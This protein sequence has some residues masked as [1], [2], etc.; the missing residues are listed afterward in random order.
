[1]GIKST[2]VFSRLSQRNSEEVE[3]KKTSYWL[4]KIF[5][6]EKSREKTPV[7]PP[8]QS[9]KQV[10][11]KKELPENNKEKAVKNRQAVEDMIN[12]SNRVLLRIY[13]VFPLDFFP[14]RI[15]VED[16]RLVIIH[17][18]LFSSQVHSVDLKDVSN[19]FIDT[20]IIFA[21]VRVISNTFAQNQIIVNKLWK[22]EAILARNV[23]EGLR[24]FI[25]NG[26]D[27]T[28]FKTEE[29]V[30]KLKELNETEIVI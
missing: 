11:P 3:T 15:I 28:S 1:M 18:Q 20:S 17:R 4:E 24:K 14:S 26:I 23:I 29:L 21:Q 19:V 13:S 12:N 16:T 9:A 27:T 8:I 22:K 25:S 30:N 5:N 7:N 10:T 6:Q 2:I